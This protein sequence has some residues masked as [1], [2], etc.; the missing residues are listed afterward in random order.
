MYDF[1]EDNVSAG[2]VAKVGEGD[3]PFEIP[4]V[5]VDIAGCNQ[6]AV[7]RQRD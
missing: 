2:I 6:A 1:L 5:A 7:G 4:P 3:E